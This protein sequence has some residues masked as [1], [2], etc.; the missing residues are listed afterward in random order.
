MTDPTAGRVSTRIG[1][2]EYRRL[3]DSQREAFD[4]WIAGVVGEPI[5]DARILWAQIGEGELVCEQLVTD[6]DG[7]P[8]IDRAAQEMV[9]RTVRYS[10]PTP[11]PVWPRPER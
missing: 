6:A 8:Q 2:R 7:T 4:E 3:D 9:T 1:P 5:A 10:A 11:P